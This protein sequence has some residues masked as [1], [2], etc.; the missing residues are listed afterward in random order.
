MAA[1]GKSRRNAFLA[2]LALLALGILELLV[3]YSGYKTHRMIP[4]GHVEGQFMTP[5]QGFIVAGI[6][7]A[8]AAYAFARALLMKTEG[9][10]SRDT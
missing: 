1:S 4:A 10:T 9:T 6:A 7:F 5:T 3:A 2:G 8:F